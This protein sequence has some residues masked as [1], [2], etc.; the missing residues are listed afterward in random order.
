[1]RRTDLGRDVRGLGECDYDV[2][3]QQA[4]VAQVATEA[5]AGADTEAAVKLAVAWAGAFGCIKVRESGPA[6]RRA[7]VPARAAVRARIRV[8]F[9]AN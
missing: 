6:V 9:M 3:L 5:V 1:M 7:A 4:Q 8:S 2:F